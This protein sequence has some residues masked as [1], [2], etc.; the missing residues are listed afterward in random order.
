M[1]QSKKSTSNNSHLNTYKFPYEGKDFW[2]TGKSKGKDSKKQKSDSQLEIQDLKT[3]PFASYFHVNLNGLPHEEEDFWIAV[4][5]ERYDLKKHTN[6]SKLEFQNFM[7]DTSVLETATHYSSTPVQ[8]PPDQAIRVNL[9]HSMNN[10]PDLPGSWVPSHVSIIAS[11][12]GN[13]GD[14]GFGPIETAKAL[15]FHHPDLMTQDP[16][17]AK[18]IMDYMD[19]EKNPSIFSLISNDEDGLADVIDDLGSPKFAQD[20][21]DDDEGWALYV[22][23]TFT[24]DEKKET[25][26]KL[27]PR[28]A[29]LKAA[30]RAMRAVLDMAQNDPKLK[31]K[32]WFE[33]IGESIDADVEID[34][35]VSTDG[36]FDLISS[37]GEG[38]SDYR[39][40]LS[41]KNEQYGLKTKILDK[42]INS[43]GLPW[44]ELKLS[45]YYLRHLGVYLVFYD[46]DDNIIETPKEWFPEG[47]IADLLRMFFK[48]INIPDLRE[49]FPSLFKRRAS[50]CGTLSPVT[51]FLGFPVRAN[52]GKTK[53]K[54]TFP[55]NKVTKVKIIGGGQGTGEIDFPETTYLGKTLTWIFEL[56][57]PAFLLGLTV[58]MN[59]SKA[60]QDLVKKNL[61]KIIAVGLVY[62][63][64]KIAA[65]AIKHSETDWKSIS[66]LTGILFKKAMKPILAHI[67]VRVTTQKLAQAVPTAGW[68]MVAVAI[69][70]TTAKIAQ[71][72]YAIVVSPNEINNDLKS[73]ISSKIIVHPDP[74]GN[75]W[76]RAANN[77]KAY[78]NCKMIYKNE[79]RAIVKKTFTIPSHFTEKTIEFEFNENTLGGRVRFE[80]EFCIDNWIAAKASTE[81]MPNDL[82]NTSEVNTY[83]F[84]IPVPLN[85]DTLFTHKSKL[86][87]KDN[88]YQWFE[89]SEA[90][91]STINNLSAAAEGNAISLFTN[92]ALN[93]RKGA[94]GISYKSF[95]TGLRDAQ[96]PESPSSS[97]LFAFQ[98][99]SVPGKPME[100]VKFTDFGFRGPSA[101][102]FNQFPPLFKMK[103]N[104]W[105]LDENNLPIPDPSDRDLGNYYIDPRKASVPLSEGGGYHLRKV[106]IEGKTNYNPNSKKPEDLLSYGRF[107]M[108]PDH[109]TLHPSGYIIGINQKHFAIMITPFPTNPKTGDYPFGKADDNL[110]VAMN[111]GGEAKHEKR[112]GRLYKPLSVCCSYDGVICILEQSLGTGANNVARIQTFNLEGVS[113]PCFVEDGKETSLLPIKNDVTYMDM[114]A[115]GNQQSTYI[116]VSYY[117]NDGSKVSDYEVAVYNF[118]KNRTTGEKYS[119]H[120]LDIKGIPAARIAV[121]MWHYLYTLNFEMTTDGN[122][123]PAG[124]KDPNSG[125]A[126]RT[127]PSV[128]EWLPSVPK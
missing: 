109:V 119:K 15:I 12:L 59:S 56:I 65:K 83:L 92:L 28:D 50:Y 25:A 78:V 48:D 126:G 77:S 63:G 36:E 124:P 19:E 7:T 91:T 60:L 107:S 45:N 103:N 100:D 64:G 27:E 75:A 72:G 88:Q 67:I 89:T 111:F 35:E 118:G 32:K 66:T 112:M 26:Y 39:A 29:V 41:I 101:L 57:V 37:E 121:S 82:E 127:V 47:Q 4:D 68:A 74:R 76:P 51:T 14:Q 110:A 125:P 16:K 22:E 80:V 38:T 58:K 42:G 99:V 87:F 54:F 2:L 85:E 102:V 116:F 62:F 9:A 5:G 23:E 93:Q 53:L 6:E 24:F 3:N 105:E 104:T 120:V 44:V 86:I 98:S 34:Y 96:N 11:A 46:A 40:A 21:P 128:S 122:N 117:K 97:Q 13:P 10:R 113:V 73:T 84:Q 123:N 20:E 81:E 49:K 18:V 79:K 52:P 106:D 94:I 95:G 71:T 61:G 33:E 31:D 43:E 30:E 8:L 70:E 55:S 108:Y 17:A 114:Q 90:P 69:A 115:V 1:K